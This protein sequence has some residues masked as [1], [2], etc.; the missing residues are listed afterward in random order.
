MGGQHQHFCRKSIICRKTVCLY[1]QNYISD[2]EYYC[3]MFTI[4]EAYTSDPIFEKIMKRYPICS[5]QIINYQIDEKH[6]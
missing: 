2:N 1:I 6:K 4:K 3:F 5:V